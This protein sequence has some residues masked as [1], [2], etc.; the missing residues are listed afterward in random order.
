MHGKRFRDKV[1]PK[2]KYHQHS[3][4]KYQGPSVP[5]HIIGHSTALPD[6]VDDA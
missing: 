3:N 6:S 4:K 2:E 5:Y 1:L